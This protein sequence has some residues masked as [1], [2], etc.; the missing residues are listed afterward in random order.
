MCDVIVAGKKRG[1]KVIYEGERKI[2]VSGSE[3][4]YYIEVTHI[5]FYRGWRQDLWLRMRA[6]FGLPLI[7]RGHLTLVWSQSEVRRSAHARV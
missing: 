7:V 3:K 2:E 6:E 5:N 1:R 4:G